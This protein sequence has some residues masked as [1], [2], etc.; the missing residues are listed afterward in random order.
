M[1]TLRWIIGGLIV[2]VGISFLLIGAIDKN[3]KIDCYKWQ[4]E[5]GTYNKYW[6]TE[7]QNEMCED[8]G[9]IIGANVI[10]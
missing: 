6:V 10:K 3:T 8:L 5:A 9:I 1:Q 2:V 7:S 4:T